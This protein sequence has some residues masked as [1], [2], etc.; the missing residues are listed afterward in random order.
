MRY[1]IIVSLNNNFPLT[2]NF[3]ENLILTTDI[4]NEGELVIISDNCHDIETIN[5][6]KS[7]SDMSFPIN[8]IYNTTSLGYGKSNNIAVDKSQGDILVF[9]NSDVFPAKGSIQSLVS[10]LKKIVLL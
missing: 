6:L 3:I 1:S 7:L 2:N 4:K 5:Y 10:Y 8:V 9:I